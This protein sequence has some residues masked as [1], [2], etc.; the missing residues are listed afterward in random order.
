MRFFQGDIGLF[1]LAKILF[2]FIQISSVSMNN[3]LSIK[4]NKIF[5][6]GAKRYI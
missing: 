1:A 6:F 4:Y 3:S 5:R 2:S